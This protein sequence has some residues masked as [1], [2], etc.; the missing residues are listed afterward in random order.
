MNL[1]RNLDATR[2][3]RMLKNNRNVFY[4][5]ITKIKIVTLMANF[6]LG[7]SIDKALIELFDGLI[8]KKGYVNESRQ[9]K[10]VGK[11]QPIDQHKR[12]K[13]GKRSLTKTEN[14]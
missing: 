7:I 13:T 3:R 10:R 9:E 1:Q 14:L 5:D 2:K 4:N 6:R 12:C 11:G 8:K